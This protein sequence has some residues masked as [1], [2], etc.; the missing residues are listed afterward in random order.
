MII[1][2][3]LSYVFTQDMSVSI[4]TVGGHVYTGLEYSF[5][6]YFNFISVS[7]LHIGDDSVCFIMYL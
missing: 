6:M 7:V 5:Y 4:D 3:L 2:C 1:R